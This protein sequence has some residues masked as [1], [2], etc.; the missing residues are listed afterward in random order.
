MII[1]KARINTSRPTNSHEFCYKKPSLAGVLAKK[2]W[3][4]AIWHFNLGCW[5]RKPTGGVKKLPKSLLLCC[6]F[7]F[8][9][10][11]WQISCEEI[12]KWQIL[13]K[14]YESTD[15]AA[16]TF[17]DHYGYEL[18][19]A[20]LPFLLNKASDEDLMVN[21]CLLGSLYTVNFYTDNAIGSIL[22]I[23]W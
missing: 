20:L 19:V 11:Q 6:S 17:N 21:P 10:Q 1:W 9:I 12:H 5:C 16:P 15:I 8:Q 22:P 2:W 18:A 14:Q 3:S 13:C 23:H 4:S 7:K